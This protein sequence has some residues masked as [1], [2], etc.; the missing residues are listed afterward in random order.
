[1]VYQ[2]FF[3]PSIIRRTTFTG[4]GS[5]RRKNYLARYM[6]HRLVSTVKSSVAAMAVVPGIWYL[7]FF[8]GRVTQF[9]YPLHWG[10]NLPQG[11]GPPPFF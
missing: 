10:V 2:A 3:P 4:V 1:M 11:P 8:F 5:F 9:Y 7:G 6:R